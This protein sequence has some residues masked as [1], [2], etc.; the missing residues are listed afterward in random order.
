MARQ[1]TQRDAGV[2][3][4]S[5]PRLRVRSPDAM[6]RRTAAPLARVPRMSSPLRRAGL[7]VAVLL[8]LAPSG[9][10][11][12]TTRDFAATALNIIPSGQQG[13]FPVPPGADRQA[14]MYDALTP[15]FDDVTPADLQR[16]FKSERFGTRGQCPCRVE[17]VPRDGVRV[18]RD[19]FDVP[20]ITAR[21]VDALTFTAGFIT[22]E[23]RGLLLEQARFDSRVA[24]IDAP[25]LSAIA[26]IAGLRTFVPSP[27]TEAEI[28][29]Q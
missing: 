29:K 18:V 25:N 1:R 5:P 24:A 21:T 8:L 16:D 22:A 15:K 6:S 23:D 4:A 13:A 2:R 19:R 27:Q 11:A 14:Q 12:Q 9:A 7:A 26:L 20:H 17:R 3:F 28:A 10:R